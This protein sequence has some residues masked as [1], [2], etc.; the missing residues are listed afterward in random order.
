V[1][2][3]KLDTA[4]CGH[5]DETNKRIPEKSTIYIYVLRKNI[6]YVPFSKLQ[7]KLIY[8]GIYQGSKIKEIG[9]QI[10]KILA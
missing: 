10:K 3:N 6:F 9:K 8:V 5:F 7:L 4:I 1:H 2:T